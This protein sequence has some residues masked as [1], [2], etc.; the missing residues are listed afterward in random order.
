MNEEKYRDMVLDH[1][2]HID[3]LANSVSELVNKVDKMIDVITKQNVLA[4]KISNMDTNLKDSFKRIH[5]RVE[6]V[7]ETA[8]NSVSKTFVYWL[9]PI[10]IVYVISFGSFVDSELHRLDV[11]I[12]KV[13]Q[14]QNIRK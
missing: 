4:E 12:N 1:D 11:S 3:T 10:I 2:K 6:K 9:I 13:E 8:N 14:I 5:E 7:E